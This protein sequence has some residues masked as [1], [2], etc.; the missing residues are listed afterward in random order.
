MPR[1]SQH[2]LRSLCMRPV[3]S[4]VLH[5]HPIVFTLFCR[6][7][8]IVFVF[9]L[10]C[11][12]SNSIWF[13]CLCVV[14]WALLQ[15]YL[16]HHACTRFLVEGLQASEW[17]QHYSSL[18]LNKVWPPRW[19]LLYYILLNMFQTLIRPSSGASE[20]LL[21][22]VGWLEACWCYVTALAVGDVVSECRPTLGYHITNSQCRYITP[23]RLK[24]AY[25]TQQVLASS[26]FLLG[27]FSVGFALY[28][29]IVIQV[30]LGSAC[31]VCTVESKA[32][33]R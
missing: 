33:F 10:F 2:Q 19:H 20:Y 17:Y 4:F 5:H 27:P 18:F 23:A 6:Y 8:Y 11:L 32:Y 26:F 14:S 3:L 31:L 24:S 16:I 28:S 9:A 15:C 29:D 25:T 7:C 22:C 30:A 12:L 21:C 1:Y 13:C